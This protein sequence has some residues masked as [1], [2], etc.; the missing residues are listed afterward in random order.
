MNNTRPVPRGV[1]QTSLRSGNTLARRPNGGIRDVHDERRGINIH[2]GLNGSR[3]I[4]V[5]RADHS[6]IYAERGRPAATSTAATNSSAALTSTMAVHTTVS[7]AAMSI[8]PAC[9]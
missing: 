1:Q 4:S 8:V 5:E 2:N 3:H 6:R 7:I 9:A